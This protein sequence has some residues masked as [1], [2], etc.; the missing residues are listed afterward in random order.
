MHVISQHTDNYYLPMST[1]TTMSSIVG[2][3]FPFLIF[4]LFC[5]L[6]QY[7]QKPPQDAPHESRILM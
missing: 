3:G 5:L 6:L 4:P 1:K 7:P 2:I